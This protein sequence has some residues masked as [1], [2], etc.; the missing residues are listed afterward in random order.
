VLLEI[1][2]PVSLVDVELLEL[3]LRTPFLRSLLEILLP[4][5][6]TDVTLLMSSSFLVSLL[7][8]LENEVDTSISSS[9]ENDDD[10][11]ENESVSSFLANLDET[12]MILYS[13]AL[14]IA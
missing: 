6:L 12:P 14:P 5:R 13:T 4:V 2:L 8:S 9:E 10:D 1:L 7:L 11:D 3:P